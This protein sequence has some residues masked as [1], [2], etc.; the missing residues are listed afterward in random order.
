MAFER[1]RGGA[2]GL[3]LLAVSGVAQAQPSAAKRETARELMA[4]ARQLRDRGD[5]EGA[6]SRFSAADAIMNVPTTGFEVAVTQAELGNLVEARESLLRVLGMA[7]AQDEA[8]PFR[9][10]RAKARALHEQLLQRIGSIVFTAGD[11]SEADELELRVDGEI[12]PRA[13]LG[14]RFRVNP[15]KHQVVARSRG[16]ELWRELDVGQGQ[17]VEV[18]LA[19]QKPPLARRRHESRTVPPPKPPRRV[20]QTGTPALA[21]VGVGVGAVGI[22]IGSVAGVSAINHKNSAADAC[23]DKRCP[24]STWLD[25]QTAHNMAVTSNVGFLIG[26]AGLAFAVGVFLLDRPSHPKQALL[27]A[28]EVGPQGASVNV[29]G[30][31]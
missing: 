16:R 24:P 25:L 22:V 6:L 1:A 21:Y 7:Q 3:A 11:V 30:R 9:E 2:L 26:G 5:L 27:V 20:P 31:F 8:A 18:R 17:S 23:I 13:M 10:A 12:V 19:F 14:L 29:Q 4:E 15:G 28:P